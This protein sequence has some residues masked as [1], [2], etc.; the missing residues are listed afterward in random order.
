[1]ATRT[2]RPR[3]EAAH[4]AILKAALRLV[5]RHGFRAVTVNEI[6]AEAGVGKMTL[7][8]HWPNKSAVVMDALLALIGDETAFPDSGNALQSLRHQ[9]DLQAA[10]FRSPRGNLIRSLVSEMQSDSELATAFRERWLIPRRVGVQR[11]MRQ[12]VSEGSLRNDFDIDTA[13]DL[14]YGAIYYRLLLGTGPLDERFIE[15][16]YQQF[17]AGHGSHARPSRAKTRPG[18]NATRTTVLP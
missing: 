15:N 18:I 2:G 6:A 4:E 12:A 10:F 8:R 14:L 11:T 1:M 9:L 5:T 7:Y 3:S 13:I 17:V 16:T